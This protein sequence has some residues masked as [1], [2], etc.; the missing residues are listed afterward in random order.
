M[1]ELFFAYEELRSCEAK[2]GCLPM[3]QEQTVGGVQNLDFLV[4]HG[5]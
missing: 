1:P 4:A 3:G 5:T 2:K